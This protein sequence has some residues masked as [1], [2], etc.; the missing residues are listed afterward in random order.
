MNRRTLFVIVCVLGLVIETIGCVE[1]CIDQTKH[2]VAQER[3]P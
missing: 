3:V 2:A 1:R